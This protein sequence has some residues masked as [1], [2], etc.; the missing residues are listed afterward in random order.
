MACA[1]WAV[2]GVS[3]GIVRQKWQPV[4]LAGV[5]MAVGMGQ[6]PEMYMMAF[7]LGIGLL[8]VAWPRWQSALALAAGGVSAMIPIW[9]L[10]YRWTGH[11]LG[12]LITH[13]SDFGRPEE[14]AFECVGPPRTIQAGRFLLHIEGQDPWTFTAAL[15]IIIG[16]FLL[17]FWLRLPQLQNSK[18]A[19]LALAATL[20]GYAM[21]TK[22]LWREPL[23]GLLTTF[24]L[25]G[26]SL[27]HL[28]YKY[29]SNPRRP[30]YRLTLLTAII[31]LAGM[32]AFWPAYGGVHWGGR[33]LLPV[34]P[35][36]IF[37]AFYV[38]YGYT[39]QES[40]RKILPIIGT[41]LLLAT[42]FLQ[43][44]GIRLF[45]QRQQA[46]NVLQAEI[47][48]LPVQ[49][50]LTN[51]PFL[52]TSLVG[53][54]E[55]FFMYIDSEEDFE[56]LIPR[57]REQNISTFAFIPVAA[58]PLTVPDQVGNIAVRQI[59]PVVYELISPP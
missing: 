39:T 3:L 35:L 12:V 9:W 15:L 1:V 20:S 42:I 51:H 56:T 49:V 34:Y 59:S 25:L 2:Y 55:K 14:Y 47:S 36:L 21:W 16:L 11:P 33:Y 13:I 45:W 41:I 58:L 22:L 37:L 8:I 28:D 17:I 29:D 53:L 32:L 4:V 30:V 6:R 10:Q 18:I 48:E 26:L 23:A 57:F 52:P 5:V 46:N 43:L 50:I 38:Y 19:I 24:P 40:V 7:A 44:L 31:F 27:T 54:E